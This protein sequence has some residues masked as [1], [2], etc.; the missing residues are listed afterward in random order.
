[1]N[2]RCVAEVQPVRER[3]GFESWLSRLGCTLVSL[4]LSLLSCQTERMLRAA[5]QRGR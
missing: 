2:L 3:A 1:M 4:C 5:F